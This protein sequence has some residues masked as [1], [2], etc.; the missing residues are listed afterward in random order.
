MSGVS[1]KDKKHVNCEYQVLM[2]EDRCRC[3]VV[4]TA[5]IVPGDIFYVDYGRFYDEAAKNFTYVK[6]VT[7]T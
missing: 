1:P 6:S 4:A 2:V 5:K 7:Q 3:F